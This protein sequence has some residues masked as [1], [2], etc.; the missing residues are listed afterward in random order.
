MSSCIYH[1]FFELIYFPGVL[2]KNLIHPHQVKSHIIKTPEFKK[3]IQEKVRR[4][5]EGLDR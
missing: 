1:F 2:S 5:L 3:K 4:V